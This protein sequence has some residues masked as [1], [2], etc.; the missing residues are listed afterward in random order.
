MLH[1]ESYKNKYLK[2]KNKYL[3]LKTIVG[4]G[5]YCPR[6]GLHQSES[7]CWHDALLMILL[8]SDQIGP[9]IQHIFSLSLENLNI[10][11]RQHIFVNGYIHTIKQKYNFLTD[12]NITYYIELCINYINAI[13]SRYHNEKKHI[14]MKTPDLLVNRVTSCDL[15]DYSLETSYSVH[16]LFGKER[17]DPF[18]GGNFYSYE[19]TINIFN[20]FIFS[21]SGLYKCTIQQVLPYDI[22]SLKYNL[23]N[24]IGYI[25]GIIIIFSFV[26]RE[27]G[28]AVSIF[29]CGGNEYFYDNEGISDFQ[30]LTPDKYDL[31]DFTMI[32]TNIM[33]E[34]ARICNDD[35]I[36]DKDKENTIKD[37]I[38]TIL[39]HGGYTKH[40]RYRLSILNYKFI[41]FHP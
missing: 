37:T 40:R 10:M 21:M 27:V 13:Y 2:Y 39:D 15:S 19:N 4:G 3:K 14:H 24:N 16:Q 31:V 28:H 5:P 6:F 17:E 38:F 35:T 41:Y 36:L 29:V 33:E 22:H 7:A 30:E 23:N 11:L 20:N 26:D 8:Y 12:G 34:M 18:S 1:I 32:R 25:A 9:F